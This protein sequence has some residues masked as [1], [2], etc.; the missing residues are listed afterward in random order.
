M[1]S[2][3][4]A[5]QILASTYTQGSSIPPTIMWRVNGS[6]NNPNNQFRIAFYNLE[7][8]QKYETGNV[9]FSLTPAAAPN[10]N[11]RDLDTASYTLT[12]QEINTALASF[13]S[14]ETI[15]IAVK[16]FRTGSPLTGPYWSATIPEIP[17][18]LS[19]S[20]LVFTPINN[21]S[22]YSL[23]DIL[24]KQYTGL[25]RI[26]STYNGKPVTHIGNGAFQNLQLSQITIPESVTNI[27]SNAFLNCTNLEKVVIQREIDN[28]TS[29]GSNAFLGCSS[30]ETIE[31][32][33]KRIIDYIS[34]TNWENYSDFMHYIV[35]ITDGLTIDSVGGESQYYLFQINE[36]TIEETITYNFYHHCDNPIE[37]T[38]Y[39]DENN[40][41]LNNA[42]W[43]GD[44]IFIELE[45]GELYKLVIE[46]TNNEYFNI[47]ID[48]IIEIE[49]E[50][51]VKYY[52]ILNSDSFAY[53][54][55]TTPNAQDDISYTINSTIVG[56]RTNMWL[57]NV[58]D[59]LITY[60]IGDI[61]RNGAK[62]DYYLEPDTTY[63]VLLYLTSYYYYDDYTIQFYETEEEV[64]HLE[65][66]G[67]SKQYF[68][69]L[70]YDYASFIVFSN[71]YNLEFDEATKTITFGMIE[72]FWDV[73]F[74]G[75]PNSPEEYVIGMMIG[76][77][78]NSFENTL[79][80]FSMNG[81]Y[82]YRAPLPYTYSYSATVTDVSITFSDIEWAN[83][84]TQGPRV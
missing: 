78:Y 41:L 71:C 43:D 8:V 25:A 60:D 84:V 70:T 6:Q 49:L 18:S 32:P 55:F 48:E 11:R 39:D 75:Y 46:T 51:G 21:N 34:A 2:F 12:Q 27:G 31:V 23:T 74:D 30:L 1:G 63:T 15:H 53:Y 22:E 35:P 58:F 82:E 59:N 16:G 37:I 73:T 42:T 3:K 40:V 66:G 77:T 17:E 5:P 61:N 67:I 62:I 57:Y 13:S 19:L 24:D 79:A 14:G 7:G 36:S 81:F 72:C 65:W 69:P 33:T 64:Y 45:E 9:S 28:I 44:P 50:L 29:L 76:M 56:A 80:F 4:I 83:F 38:I 26:P 54:T 20:S 47:H 10:Q 68:D 52:E